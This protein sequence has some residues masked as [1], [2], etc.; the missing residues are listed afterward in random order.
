LQQTFDHA[1][2]ADATYFHDLSHD[3]GNART[4]TAGFAFC[5]LGDVVGKFGQRLRR[6]DADATRNAD[7]LQDALAHFSAALGDVAPDAGDI[8]K[9]LVDGVHLLLVAKSCSQTHHAVADIA[10]QRE[11]GCVFR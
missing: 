2:N 8:H 3:L 6:A 5:R 10:V 7:P 1:R 4:L 9:G 11:V